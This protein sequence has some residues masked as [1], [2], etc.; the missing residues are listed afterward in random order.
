MTLSNSKANTAK[1]KGNANMTSSFQPLKYDSQR[2]LAHTP[3]AIRN[4]L[5]LDP[6]TSLP[7]HLHTACVEPSAQV[8]ALTDVKDLKVSTTFYH[9]L[10]A[11]SCHAHTTAHRKISQLKQ[12][13]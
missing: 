11:C 9:S 1:Q 12:V 2:L 4:G 7:D 8:L 10:D 6:A 3:P 13:K 5:K